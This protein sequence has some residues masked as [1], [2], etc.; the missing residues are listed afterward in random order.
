MNS[1]NKMNEMLSA[2]PQ[3][4]YMYFKA[5]GA[6]KFLENHNLKLSDP[7]KCNDPFECAIDYNASLKTTG[8]ID[9][10]PYYEQLNELYV[11]DLQ[12]KW[13]KAHKHLR[14]SCF[15][16]EATNILMWAYYADGQKGICIEFDPSKDPLFFEN[17]REVKYRTKLATINKGCGEELDYSEILIT[18]A[19]QWQHEK[20]WR[21]IFKDLYSDFFPISPQA[22]TSV[23]F[24][25]ASASYYNDYGMS[26]T[27]ER[28][29][30]LLQRP[31]Y[32]H[33]QL[34]C[35]S[36]ETDTFKLQCRKMPFFV[37]MKDQHTISIIST[38]Q[39]CLQIKRY[40]DNRDLIYEASVCQWEKTIITLPNG[41]YLISNAVDNNTVLVQIFDE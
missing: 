3:R 14:I 10:N 11:R 5:E 39:Q 20:E 22:I 34:Q 38:R 7:R 16:K 40:N 17:L 24:G 12:A 13:W 1:Y 27:Y 35:I 21:V 19:M 29:F 18:K 41:Y 25:C 28:I 9:E 36:Q 8:Y 37:F 2:R 23:I 32:A 26:G 30:Q 4:L 33:I 15:T 6:E 31:E